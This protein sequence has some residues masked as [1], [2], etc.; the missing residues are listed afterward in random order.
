MRGKRHPGFAALLIAGLLAFAA[1]GSASEITGKVVLS[2]EITADVVLSVEGFQMESAP[3]ATIYV[4]DHRDLNFT[5]HVLV[6]R[7]GSTVRFENS[8]GMPCHIYSISPAG[9]FALRRQDGKPMAIKFDRPGTI[10]VRCAEH[11]RIYAYIIIKENPYFALTDRK[12]RYKISKLRPGRYVM[13]AWYEGSVLATKTV[14]VGASKLT[15]DF[16]A[17]RPEP[18]VEK[19]PADL[20]SIAAIA[21]FSNS[22]PSEMLTSRRKEQ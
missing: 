11:G 1:A 10:V 22:S 9:L 17:D 3:D 20:S 5:P 4:V 13:Q 2:G 12:G 18:H 8:D 7:A 16:K 15:L 14:E 21:D 6:I 19:Q